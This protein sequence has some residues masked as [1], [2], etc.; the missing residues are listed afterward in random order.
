M[1]LSSK[2]TR[3]ARVGG[4]QDELLGLHEEAGLA[5]EHLDDDLVAR[6]PLNLKWPVGPARGQ[7]VLARDGQSLAIGFRF[8][9]A[10]NPAPE[11]RAW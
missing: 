3:E 7:V 1:C 5:I 10:W 9:E 11:D 6:V 8:P 2:E 4:S